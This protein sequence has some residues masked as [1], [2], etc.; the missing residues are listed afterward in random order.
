MTQ[1]QLCDKV[2]EAIRHA[3]SLS[4]DALE[5]ALILEVAANQIK[6]QAQADVMRQALWNALKGGNR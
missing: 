6:A 2:R 3:E 5:Q 1:D 4:T